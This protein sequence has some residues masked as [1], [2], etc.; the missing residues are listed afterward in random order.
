MPK[1]IIIPARLDSQRLPRKLLKKDTG[2]PLIW[3][4]IQNA[5]SS[6]I[7]SVIVATDSEE[8][9]A[10]IKGET[11]VVMTGRCDSGTQRVA[12]A[13]NS[14]GLRGYIVNVQGD[15]PEVNM[16]YVDELF[17]ALEKGWDVVTIA[18][19]ASSEEYDN[20]NVVKV[21]IGTNDQ[22]MYFSR[23]P[24]PHGGP[25]NSLKHIGAYAYRSSFLMKLHA[26][27]PVNRTA[28]ENLE[29]LQWLEN[30]YK[31]K[32]LVRNMMTTGIDTQ[33]DYDRFV[34]AYKKTSR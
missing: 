13:Q 17:I 33:E 26:L 9:M 34:N 12:A 22:A 5:K 7:A 20:P 2:H 16:L 19:K 18:T 28:S 25:Q 27:T 30:G 23:S 21:V 1:Y 11:E 3:H 8:I 29:Q 15:E 10:A 4:T 6:K 31:I 24:I 14:L 32:V